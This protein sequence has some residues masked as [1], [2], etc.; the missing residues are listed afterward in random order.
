MQNLFK[1]L[2]EASATTNIHE[3]IFPTALKHEN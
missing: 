1:S 2:S 3:L